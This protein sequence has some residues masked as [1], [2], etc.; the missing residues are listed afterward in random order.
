MRTA[1]MSIRFRIARPNDDFSNANASENPGFS[2][3]N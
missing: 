1:P 3:A 2:P